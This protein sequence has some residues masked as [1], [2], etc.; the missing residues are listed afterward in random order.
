MCNY[1]KGHIVEPAVIINELEEIF[2][3]LPKEDY[4]LI[5]N[6]SGSFLD[7]NE[8]SQSL[9]NSMYSLLD[10][11]AFESLTIESRADVLSL[12][13]LHELRDRFNTRRVSVEI[14]VET[15]NDWLLRY[16]VNKGVTVGQIV[17]AVHLIHEA[18]LLSIANL[19]LGIPFLSERENISQAKNSILKAFDI[20][21]ESVILFPYHIKPGTLLEV[22]SANGRYHCVSLWSLIEVLSLLPPAV[23][24]RVN[25]SWYKNYYTDKTKVIE[26]PDTCPECRDKVLKMLDEYKSDPSQ[27]ALSPMLSFECACRDKWRIE[28]IGTDRSFKTDGVQSDYRFLS[29]YFN[30]DYVLLNEALSEMQD[31][32]YA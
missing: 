5:V 6:P 20:G 26:S 18:G 14:G 27:R 9:R 8:V 16:A 10:K 2:G 11:I 1:G 17:Q 25:I 13:S 22:L 30:I 21:F 32:R 23:L 15:L 3:T 28:V 12:Q 7:E 31:A 24:Q 29:E 19:G 4:N